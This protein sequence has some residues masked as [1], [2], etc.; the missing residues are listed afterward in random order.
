MHKVELLAPAG[1]LEKLKFAVHYGADAVYM[2][3]KKYGLRAFAGNFSEDELAEGVKYAHEHQVKV[4]VTVNIF[5]HNED[6]KGLKE[7]LQELYELKVDGI[8]VANPG[9]VMIAHETVPDLPIHISTQANITNWA[10]VAFW[11]KYVGVERVVLARELSLEEIREIKEKTGIEIETFV[12]GAM[13]ISYSGRCLLSCYM[14][15]RDANKGECAQPCRWNY[16]LVEEKR[17][18]EYFAIEEDERGSYVFNSQDMCLLPHLADLLNGTID[19]LKIEGRMKSLYYTSTIV[20]AYR[21]VLDALYN[22]EEPD[23]N[24]WMQ[25][26]EKVSHRPYC[27]GFYYGRPENGALTLNHSGYIKPYDFIGVVVDYDEE[28]SIA[29]IEQRNHFKVGDE[30]EFFSPKYQQF[31]LKIEEMQDKD[32]NI[33]LKAPNAQMLVR[34]K[35][36]FKVYPLDLIRKESE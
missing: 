17:P 16:A 5:P 22:G 20:R 25:E 27:T 4:Y 30:I 33:I 9:I 23:Y 19:S 26:L 24:Y 28:S 35:V 12:H 29:T 10:D 6:L 1:N 34:L 7:Y 11:Q 36:P 14:T 32:G 31:Q 3:G 13:C 18:G 8:I 15:G 2:A 21:A